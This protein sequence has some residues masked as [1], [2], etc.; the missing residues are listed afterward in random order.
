[1]APSVEFFIAYS[2]QYG[3]APATVGRE[4]SETAGY[5]LTAADLPTLSYPGYTF[6]GWSATEGGT[7]ILAA[8]DRPWGSP[9]TDE[10]K[11]LYAVWEAARTIQTELDRLTAAKADLAEAITGKGVTVPENTKLD[12]YAELVG[13][14][15][16]GG[17]DET[18]KGLIERTITEITLPSDLTKIGDYVFST[19][20]NLVLTELPAGV[21]EIGG[22]AF[23]NCSNLALTELPAGMTSIGSWAFR[24]CA[25]LISITFLGTPKLVSSSAFSNC[26]NLTDIYVPWSEGAVA[27]APWG[28]TDATMHY[29]WTGETE[30]AE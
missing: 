16:G 28:A 6:L 27:N 10:T 18:L 26:K 8:G 30:S 13:Q 15:E 2:T 9:N 17:D 21:T 14:I 23:A 24:S 7:Y 20:S 22:Y 19:C 5:P 3:T 12:G 4:N 25:G 29:D 11:T 1:M